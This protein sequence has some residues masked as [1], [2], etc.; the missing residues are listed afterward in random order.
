MGFSIE[1]R[2]AIITGA[3]NGVGLAIARHFA[4]KGANVMFADMDEAKLIKECGERPD[5]GNMRYFAGDL[6]ERLTM[7]NL[8]SATLDAFDRVDILVNGSRQMITSDPLDL[9][10]QSVEQMLTQ[11][12]MTALRMTQL[13]ARRMIKQAEDREDGQVGAIVNLSSIAARR[14]HPSLLGYSVSSAA[15]DQMTRSMAVALAPERIRVNAVAFGSVMSTSLKDTLRE[16]KNYREDIEDH[17][18]LGRIA[19]PDELAQTVQFLS[20]EGSGF[21]T[22]QIITVD[23]GRTLLDPVAAP[24]H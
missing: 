7:A 1:G 5:D 3:A 6:R 11:N 20:G 23:G 13:V 4:D 10:D 21:V 17:T 12:V 16:H 15:L 8:L 24:A 19:A 18:P 9:D 2:T 22:G 14:T